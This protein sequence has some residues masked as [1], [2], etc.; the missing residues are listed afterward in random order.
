MCTFKIFCVTNRHL[1][2]EPL[3]ERIRRLLAAGA[4]RI[5]LREKDLTEMEYENLARSLLVL[6]NARQRLLLHHFPEAAKRLHADSLQL[7]LW[8]LEEKPALIR[9]FPHIG[10]SVHSADEAQ[11]AEALGASWIIAGHIYSTDCKRGLPG[12]GINFLQEVCN[13]VSIPVYAIGG[14]QE[15][16]IR[17]LKDAKAAGACI[18]SSAMQCPNPSFYLSNLREKT[19]G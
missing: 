18:M 6:P 16:N 1:C 11:Q 9:T 14:I 17:F 10:V 13:A 4:D 19:K 3:S 5:L 8:Q 2:A 12:R 15:E 7:S